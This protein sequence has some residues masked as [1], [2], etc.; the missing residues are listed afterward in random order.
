MSRIYMATVGADILAYH[1][2]L[3]GLV[4]WLG[5]IHEEGDSIAVWDGP[6]LILVLGPDG[7]V[8]DLRPAEA[9]R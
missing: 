1:T 8:T 3:E 2:T 9:R 6:V 7:S 5:C 4:D